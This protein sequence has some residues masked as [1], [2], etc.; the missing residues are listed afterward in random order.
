M[1]SRFT[2]VF[3]RVT[4]SYKKTEKGLAEFII[5]TFVP[6]KRIYKLVKHGVGC[7]PAVP[8]HLQLMTDHNRSVNG[9]FK[10]VCR[11]SILLCYP[12]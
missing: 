7:C 6:S 3:A 2:S 11:D 12:L 5:Y 9:L 8:V 4:K 1:S 10:H